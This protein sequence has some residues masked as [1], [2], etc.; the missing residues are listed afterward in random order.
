[1]AT[2]AALSVSFAIGDTF[3]SVADFQFKLKNYQRINGCSFV[4]VNSKSANSYNNTLK[5]HQQLPESATHYSLLYNCVHNSKR[6]RTRVRYVVHSF[7]CIISCLFTE[8]VIHIA[9]L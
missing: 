2:H 4:V 3:D 7:L 8:L 1:M 9:G 6:N 5:T